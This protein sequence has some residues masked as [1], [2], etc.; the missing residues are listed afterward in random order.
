MVFKV[1]ICF[2]MF[3]CQVKRE[4]RAAE[5]TVSSGG[6]E[7]QGWDYS[8]SKDPILWLDISTSLQCIFLWQYRVRSGHI[9]WSV[10]TY[11]LKDKWTARCWKASLQEVICSHYAVLNKQSHV[12]KSKSNCGKKG[13]FTLCSTR[14]WHVTIKQHNVPLMVWKGF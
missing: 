2:S 5:R 7:G 11:M 1:S 12:A 8:T 4:E 14:L 13:A 10:F 6:L 9:A 3:H